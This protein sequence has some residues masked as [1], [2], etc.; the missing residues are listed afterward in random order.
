MLYAKRLIFLVLLSSLAVATVSASYRLVLQT[1]H[2][3]PP[4]AFEWHDSS[5]TVVSAGEDGRIIVTDP[6]I[7]K[8]L[9]RFRVSSDPIISLK[10]APGA[11]R[12]AVVTSGEKGSK[13][14]VWDWDDEEK[15]YDFSLDSAPLFLSWSAKGRYLVA[16]NLGTPSILVLEGRT[17]RR[18]SYLQ[19]LPSLYNAGYI[20][21]TETILMTYASS[22]AIRYWDIRSAA[23]KGSSETI[24]NLQDVKVLQIEDADHNKTMMFGRRNES[25]YIINR[26]TGA[27]MDQM[28]VPNL[29]DVAIDQDTGEVKAVTSGPSGSA[30]QSYRVS[31]GIFLSGSSNPTL[32]SSVELSKAFGFASTSS[33]ILI[34][35]GK[36]FLMGTDGCLYREESS[37]IEPVLENNVWRPD[38][39]AFSGE[40]LFI[41][42]DTEIIRFESP[43]FAEDSQGDTEDLNILFQDS[44]SSGTDSSEME[45]NV[46]PDGRIVTW[47]KDDGGRYGTGYRIFNYPD[48][49][50]SPYVQ[51]DAVIQ[52]LDIVD[53]EHLLTIDRSGTVALIDTPT[54]EAYCTF[55]ALG[56]LDAAY[57][58]E[59]DFILVG[60]SS[61]SSGSP[62]EMIDAETRE[63]MPIEDSRFMVYS[64]EST[65]Q[66]FYSIGVKPDGRGFSTVLLQ[67]DK[68]HPEKTKS[69]L[70]V[71]GE[72][73]DALLFPHPDGSGIITTIG[74]RIR[75]ID[76]RRTIE[77]KWREPLI[78]LSLRGNILYG[79]DSD[80]TLVFWNVQGGDAIL[81]VHFFTDGSLIA[82]DP[83][84][85]MI[86]GSPGGMENVILYR[87]GQT[88]DPRRISRVL[89]DSAVAM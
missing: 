78:A 37:G 60:K 75:K 41:G 89:E 63:T 56:I 68:T 58:S 66:A 46:L 17:G 85:D 50:S 64:I 73:L 52:E 8:V 79:I 82:L 13:I 45:L 25:L 69:L 4:V 34:K 22:G 77:Y 6:E 38:S 76:S 14:A 55:S 74:D 20:G 59:G 30:I 23:L 80:G 29:M 67:H 49:Q 3:G 28:D 32:P 33:D 16:G 26:N 27:V 48:S 11:N 15:I 70:K 51:S 35:N 1:G 44:S 7:G 12:V 40:S 42:G 88:V 65:P 2:D 61:D 57:S 83:Q 71:A 87:N 21:S 72:D 19:R 53:E 86:W 36:T 39:L 43:F 81:E 5:S 84:G 54:G 31:G 24:G 18:L 10:T 9:H 62:L 47:A